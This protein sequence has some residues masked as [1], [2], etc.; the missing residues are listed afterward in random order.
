M[1][2]SMGLRYST[3]FGRLNFSNVTRPSSGADPIEVP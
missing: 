1:T 2:T 3:P